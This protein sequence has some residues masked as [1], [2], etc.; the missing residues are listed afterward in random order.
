MKSAPLFYAT[1]Y[2]EDAAI[3][4]RVGGISAPSLRN[5]H[6]DFFTYP[7]YWTGYDIHAKSFNFWFIEL[8]LELELRI[9]AMAYFDKDWDCGYGC[10]CHHILNV[11]RHLFMHPRNH[12]YRYLAL[13][14]PAVTH[15]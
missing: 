15:W 10:R 1:W 7:H 2:C 14:L 9:L 5:Q 3:A 4:R 13:I 8:E 12:P 6:Y 11:L